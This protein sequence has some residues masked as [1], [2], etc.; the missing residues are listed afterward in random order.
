MI[1][2]VTSWLD[3]QREL[4]NI[5]FAQGGNFEGRMPRESPSRM[6]IVRNSL[7]IQVGSRICL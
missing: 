4:G 3:A 1:L 7:V 6:V 5:E 2:P